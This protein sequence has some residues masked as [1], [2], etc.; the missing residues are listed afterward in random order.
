MQEEFLNLIQK[1]F[2][3]TKKP[4]LEIAKK[5][6][7][8]EDEI[9]KLYK[10]LK[11]DKIIRQTS[12]IFDTKSL[13]YQSSLVA[14]NVDDIENVAQIINSHPGVSH[15]YERDD[16]FNLWFTIAVEPDSIF[17]LEE[18]VKFLANKTK[19]KDYIILPT[20]KM[21]KIFVQ[22]DMKGNQPKKE[23][24]THYK[25]EPIKLDQKNIQ[26][27]KFL[28]K[29]I[30]P[31]SEPFEELVTKMNITYEQ[32]ANE[33]ENFKNSGVLRRFAAILYHRKAGFKANA[34]I[35]WKV[36][37]ENA[38][39]IGKKI[40]E[41]KNVSH[42]YLRPTF[43]QWPYS[44]FSMMHA[45]NKDEI[46]RVVKEITKELPIQEYKYLYSLREFKKQRIKYF[47]SEFKKW[48]ELNTSN[49]ILQ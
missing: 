31:I 41:Y 15:N 25:K 28:Q 42:C 29:D 9:I 35:V 4:F 13:G 44:L 46:D 49:V 18:T 20:K 17:G 16:K 36:K 8:Q 6:N 19:T 1:D 32:L 45:K 10:K 38:D 26:L 37:E 7:S 21:F 11:D 34:M 33:V 14:F 22:L 47:S 24:I 27:I 23:K 43:A 5:L 48:E 40:A 3:V 2:P 12:A 39:F 30:L